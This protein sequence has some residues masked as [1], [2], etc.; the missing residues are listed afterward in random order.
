MR[1]AERSGAK[2]RA[3]T[4]TRRETERERKKGRAAAEKMG[5]VTRVIF[6]QSVQFCRSH[7]NHRDKHE[8]GRGK[9]TVIFKSREKNGPSRD[10]DPTN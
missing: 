5:K 4:T 6:A 7:E 3:G 10:G 8:N 1:T 9:K 2:S